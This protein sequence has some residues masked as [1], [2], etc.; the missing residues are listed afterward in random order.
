MA[1]S[2]TDRL[3]P[4]IS[5]TSVLI[6]AIRVAETAE[7]YD[8]MVRLVKLL[9]VQKSA[10]S[11]PLSLGERN[12]FS[13]AYKNTVGAKRASWRT[14]NGGF[15]DADSDLIGKYQ[16]GIVEKE[17]ST[18]C[19][20]AIDLV[21]N[22]LYPVVKDQKSETEVF[23]LKMLGDYYRY[24]AEINPTDDIKDRAVTFY[25]QSMAV[26]ETT[27]RV[28]HPTRLGLVLN[29]SVMRFELLDDPQTALTVAQKA[30]DA[31]IED[32]DNLDQSNYKDSTMIMQLL[33]DNVTL[34]TS[35]VEER[36]NPEFKRFEDEYNDGMSACIW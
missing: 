2:V 29:F 33:R 26:A 15:D 11:E 10:K 21:L 35:E 27:L 5:S 30:F 16:R 25:Q 14:L 7:R 32:L 1:S 9:V 19:Q 20:E 31:A 28:T 13:V 24:L 12:L 3:S 8:D 6:Q 34:W 18:L 36:N 22:H 4:N 17:L 23:Y